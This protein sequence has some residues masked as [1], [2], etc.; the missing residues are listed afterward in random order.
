ML[1]FREQEQE[2]KRHWGKAAAKKVVGAAKESAGKQLGDR[3]GHDSKKVGKTSDGTGMRNSAHSG[4]GMKKRRHAGVIEVE[5]DYGVVVAVS[6]C[7]CVSACVFAPMLRV[8]VCVGVGV[9]ASSCRCVSV[10]MRAR[11]F[12]PCAESLRAIACTHLRID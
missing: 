8:C 2:F 9:G 12:V 7:V 10:C 5:P 4:T 1:S 11:A 3:L 6:A